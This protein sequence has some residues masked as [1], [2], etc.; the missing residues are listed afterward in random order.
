[1]GNTYNEY[2]YYSQFLQVNIKYHQSP[3]Y[4]S[5]N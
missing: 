3:E 1:M 4:Y 5:E 2:L